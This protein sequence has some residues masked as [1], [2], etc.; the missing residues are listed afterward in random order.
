MMNIEMLNRRSLLA[1]AGASL[2]P[3]TSLQAQEIF[4][5][6]LINLIVP[7]PPGGYA[8]TMA[9][10]V[11]PALEKSLNKTVLI[12][13]RA[14]AGGA[15]GAAFVA[16]ALPDGY[17]LLFTLS[18][19][20]TLPEQALVNNQ[21]PTFSLDQLKPLARM[22]ADPMAIIVKTSSQYKSLGDL[23]TA[24]KAKPDTLNYASSGNYGTVHVPV[25]MLLHDADV[26]IRHIPYSGGAPIMVALLGDQVDFT[27]LPRSSIAS[28]VRAGKVRILATVG[29][30][31]WTDYPNTATT[32]AAGLKFDYLPWTGLFAPA[33]TPARITDI[34][35]DAMR[36][37]ANDVDLKA[38]LNKIDGR[39]AYMDAPEF[40]EFFD[41]EARKLTQVVR[42]MG[43]LE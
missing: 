14:G 31:V 27:M 35:R 1:M 10:V 20:T 37:A 38:S 30:D 26:K 9:R 16:Q 13:N 6:K 34:L 17:T 18:G 42:R 21:K 39:L 23:L 33:Q 2:L 41:Q 8:D 22:T 3:T 4:P 32:V 40:K 7:Y 15:I 19:L 25:E 43:K 36:A 11:A 5:S 12:I 29:K 28:Q 24:A